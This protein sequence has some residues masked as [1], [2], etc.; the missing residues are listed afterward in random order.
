MTVGRI[1]YLPLLGIG[2]M[3]R[4]AAGRLDSAVIERVWIDATS[5]LPVRAEST[6]ATGQL[7]GAATYA[8]LSASPASRSVISPAPVP[9]GFRLTAEPAH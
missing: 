1:D 6:T 5:Y 8:W 2:E 7:L 9:I 3:L 4:G